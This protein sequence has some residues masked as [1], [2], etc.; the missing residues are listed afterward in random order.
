MRQKST[1]LQLEKTGPTGLVF[2]KAGLL[3]LLVLFLYRNV[4]IGLLQT[5]WTDNNASHGFLVPLI[6]AYLAWERRETIRATP[7]QPDW[8]GFLPLLFG[9]GLLTAGTV[10]AELFLPRISLL[11]LLVGLV[12]L[13][14]GRLQLKSLIFPIGVLVLMI[15]IP[16]IIF[17]HITFPLQLLASRFSVFALDLWGV[18]V[19]REGNV[20][21]LPNTTLEVAEACSGI[22]SLV[23]LITLGL[24]FSYFAHQ[25]FWSRAL[26]TL[27][28]IPI[29]VLANSFRVAGTGLLSYFYS[30]EAAQGFFHEFA[31]WMVFVVAFVFMFGFSCLLRWMEKIDASSQIS[32]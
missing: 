13:F 4:F 26:L 30:P 24:V 5:W 19:L 20:I 14:L 12:L 22:R 9:L 25:K 28:A 23:S 31:G 2:I 29:S 21:I 17:N 3:I 16:A 1:E 27:S 6:A 32:G 11:F 18:P 8:L 10:G 7:I 15:P